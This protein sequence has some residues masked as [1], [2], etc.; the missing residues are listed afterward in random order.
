MMDRRC[1]TPRPRA[2]YDIQ[3]HAFAAK[4]LQLFLDTHP[5]NGDAAEAL[6]REMR[7]EREATRAFERA[8]GPITLRAA[9]EDGRYRWEYGQRKEK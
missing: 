7:L 8:Y 2:L 4:E 1:M 3:T 6:D 9:V 5:E